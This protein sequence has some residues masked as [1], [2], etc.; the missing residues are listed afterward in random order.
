[1]DLNKHPVVFSKEEIERM[2]D[3]TRNLKHIAILCTTYSAGLR[4][5]EVLN[6]RIGDIDSDRLQVL[7]RSGKGRKTR[8]SILGQRTL[9]LLRD[10][11]KR[12]RPHDYLFPGQTHGKPLS[13]RT[14]EVIFKQAMKQAKINEPAYF[15]CL[16][17]SFATHLLEQG[18]NLKI[19]QQ[20]MGHTSLKT[21]AMYLHVATCDA[22]LVQSPI[23]APVK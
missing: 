2:L 22:L 6:L 13:E 5:S 11:W 19:I 10:Y 17:H 21:T 20:L 9:D 4:K 8:Y 1:M 16:R 23:D 15:H 12:Y 14:V 3:V 7:I 18:V